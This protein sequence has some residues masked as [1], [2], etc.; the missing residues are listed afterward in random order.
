MSH[1]DI[2]KIFKTTIG[3]SDALIHTWFQNGKDSIRVRYVDHT[4]LIFTYHN[5]RDWKLETVASFV[6]SLR[7]GGKK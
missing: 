5:D 7:E 2:F 1:N 4:E 3:V 6:N